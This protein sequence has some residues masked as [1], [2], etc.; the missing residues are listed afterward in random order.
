M[1]S[2]NE[3]L[4]NFRNEKLRQDHS[5][6]NS[7][8]PPGWQPYSEFT[9]QIG[10]AIVRLPSPNATERDLLVSAGF[11]PDSWRISGAI[12][13]RRWMRA[14]QEWLY[15]YKFDVVAGESE[16]VI[17]EHIED[18]VKKIR[19]RTPV[20]K[21]RSTEDD[22]F[23]VFASDWQIGKAE[24]GF[25]TSDTIDRVTDCF[26][27]AALRV[28]ELRKTGRSIPHGVLVGMGDIVEGCLGNYSTQL[29]TTD[30]N[31]RDQN[32]IARELIS[33]GIDTLSP[34]F[35]EFTIA[36][37]HGNHGE[38]RHEG[39][40]ITDDADN[41]DTACF[42][43][44][45]EAYDRA[46]QT[47][48]WYIP[49]DEMSTALTLGG[50]KIGLTHG[51]I[52]RKGSTPQQKAVEWFKSADFGFQ[53]V[54][55]SQILVSAHF[56]HLLVTEVGHRTLIQCPALDP[57]S[58]WYRDSTGEDAPPGMLTFRL[59]K[60]EVMGYSDLQVLRPAN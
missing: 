38:H 6:D 14:D 45:K 24:G 53:P 35:E 47:F 41:D 58:K 30:K 15:Y 4:A 27:K 57:G 36:C 5:N 52:F 48:N 25:G 46:G 42:E 3:L 54:R 22:A 49:D 16:E 29:F 8:T 19:Q 39:K 9:D 13:V 18:L 43:T 17:E 55:G 56:H 51:H 44:V 40:K 11:D 59:S 33:Y 60:D 31:R 23:L 26:D 10:E 32:K 34:L 12:N 1:L 21:T 2:E 28:K 37:V 7:L 50:V 20:N